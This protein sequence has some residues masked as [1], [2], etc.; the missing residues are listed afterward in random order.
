MFSLLS[1]YIKKCEGMKHPVRNI[2]EVSAG[3]GCGGRVGCGR[4]RGGQGGQE[5]RGGYKVPPST[6]KEIAACNHM[7]DQYFYDKNYKYF[8][9]SKKARLW[10]I[11]K[12]ITGNKSNPSHPTSTTNQ[13][14]RKI[15]ELKVTLYDL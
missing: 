1:D 7:S 9:L 2:S 3:S 10:Q 4:G 14:K 12:K 11:H 5:G 15:G 6:A 13:V 8:S